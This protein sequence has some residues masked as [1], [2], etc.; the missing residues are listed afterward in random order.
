MGALLLL[1]LGAAGPA[2]PE[3]EGYRMEAFRAPTPATLQG[4]TV[5]TTAEAERLWRAG[6]ILVDVLPQPRAPKDL[7]PGTIFRLPPR[8]SLPGATWLVDVGYGA[9]APQTEAYFRRGLDRARSERPDQPIVIFCERDC[10]MSWNAAKR[11]VAWGYK[12][13]HWYPDGT[14]GWREAGLPLERATP[15]PEE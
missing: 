6:A 5:V 7:A 4:A 3:P 11:A 13:I 8:D 9:L 2:P 12:G 10:W 1:A 14:T 15:A